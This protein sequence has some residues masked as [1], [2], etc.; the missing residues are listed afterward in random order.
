MSVAVEQASSPVDVTPAR[1]SIPA[2]RTKAG[3]P[4]SPRQ[5]CVGAAWKTNSSS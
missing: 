2:T 5:V 4:E 1:Y 3:P